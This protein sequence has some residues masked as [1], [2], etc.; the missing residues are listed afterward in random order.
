MLDTEPEPL[1]DAIARQACEVCGTPI[2]LV[3]FIDSDRQWFKAN[4]GLPGLLQTPRKLAFCAYTITQSSLFEVGD[5]AGDPRFTTNPLVTGPTEVRFYAGVPLALADGERVGTLCVLDRRPR[6]LEP[7]QRQALHSLAELAAAALTMRQSLK[8]QALAARSSD[9]VGAAQAESHY[10]TIVEDQLELVSVAQLDGTLVYVNPA[11][12]QHFGKTPAELAGVSLYDYVDAVDRDAVRQL[13]SRLAASGDTATTENRMRDATGAERWVAWTNRIRIDGIGRPMLHSVGRDVTERKAAEDA[14]RASQAFMTRSGRVAGVG[15]WELDIASG[16]VTWSEETLRIHEV[17]DDFR[18]TLDSAIAFYAP[19][20]RPAIEDAVKRGME[21]GQPWDLEL[22]LTTAKGRSIWVRAVG[23]VERVD[24]HPVRLIGAFQD[25]T[26]R[27]QLEA[28]VVDNERFLRQLTDSLPLR[29]AYLDRE[30]RYRFANKELLRHFG[31]TREEVIG[32]TR[33]ELR[34]QEDDTLLGLR[35]QEALLGQAQHFEFDE[36]VDGQTRRIENR[37]I[38]DR[39]LDGQVRGFFVTGV[40]ITQRSAAEDALHELTAIFDNTTDFIVQTDWRGRITYLNPSARAALGIA[41]DEPIDGLDFGRFNT[42]DTNRKFAQEVVPVVKKTGVWVGEN[43]VILAGGRVVPVSHMVLAHRDEQGR[44]QSYSGILRD[45]SAQTLAGQEIARQT[46]TLRLVAEAIPATVTVIDIDGSYRFVNTAFERWCGLPR[47][48]ILGRKA[49]E[50]FGEAG[51]ARRLPW[52][53]RVLLGEEVT[54][55]LAQG[56]PGEQRYTQITYVPL[57]LSTGKVD[58]YVSVA[59]DITRQKLEE[60]RLKALAQKDA[61][62]GLFNRAGFEE[63]L[64]GMEA[65]GQS[66]ALLYIDLDL[67]KPVN[68]TYGHPVGDEVLR[69]FGQRLTHLVRPTDFIARMGGDEFAI[70]LSGL[71]DGDHAG[72]L[73]EKVLAAAKRPFEIGQFVVIVSAS[74]GVAYSEPGQVDWREL[75]ARSDQKLLIAKA[76]GRGRQFSETR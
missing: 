71:P 63:A 18:P 10:R 17:G 23:E 70:A 50:V 43:T 21:T 20:A 38:P 27:R 58:G 29:I 51:F 53:H 36:P 5:A 14:L 46:E 19:Q 1:F 34:P 40:D 6:Q 57:R 8:T 41:P 24:G 75:V 39:G 65:T 67:F 15:G 76:A 4:V 31:R 44:V 33:A 30:R 66:L 62:T 25:V 45:V 64:Q 2:A 74:V 28:Q 60:V 54:F 52:I 22:P 48:E 32:R 69:S 47:A 37:L 7:S 68:D 26:A 56:G 59:Q 42:P 13:V 72:A 55:E 9:E 12:A 35:A 3:S 49:S 16:R 61:L 11:Y 73:A